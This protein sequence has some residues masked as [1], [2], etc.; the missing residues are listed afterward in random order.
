[1]LAN[2]ILGSFGMF[3]TIGPGTPAPSTAAQSQQSQQ[4]QN[5]TSTPGKKG[6]TSRKTRTR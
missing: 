4:A 2:L 1:M 3:I 5:G 6:A